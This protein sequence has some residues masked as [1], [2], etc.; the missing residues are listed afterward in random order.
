MTQSEAVQARVR[1]YEAQGVD[2]ET[3]EAIVELEV[4][5]MGVQV[6]QL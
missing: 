5:Q 3:A 2:Q 6:E 4:K 1:W